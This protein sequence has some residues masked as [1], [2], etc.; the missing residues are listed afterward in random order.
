MPQDFLALNKET[1]SDRL[2]KASANATNAL[3]AIA[4]LDYAVNA[5]LKIIGEALEADRVTV[6]EHFN[7]PEQSLHCW[8]ILYEWDSPGTVSQISHLEVSQGTYEGI[9]S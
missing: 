8:K 4:S 3:L 2:L 5:A 6:I 1:L 7:C 9:E